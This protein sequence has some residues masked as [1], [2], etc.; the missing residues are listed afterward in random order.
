MNDNVSF[1]E[2]EYGDNAL[3]S[4]EVQ[5]NAKTVNDVINKTYDLDNFHIVVFV[6]GN[7]HDITAHLEKTEPC[8][9]NA[10]KEYFMESFLKTL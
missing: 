6:Q 7:Y 2:M 3:L 8:A 1:F 10:Y 9:L 4:G 5:T